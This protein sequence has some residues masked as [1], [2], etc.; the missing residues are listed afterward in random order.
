MIRRCVYLILQVWLLAATT[1][2][3]LSGSLELTTTQAMALVQLTLPLLHGGILS[4][5]DEGG[6]H[7]EAASCS[8]IQ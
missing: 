8:H 4:L 7:M 1:G 5:F 6:M 3:A 2:R